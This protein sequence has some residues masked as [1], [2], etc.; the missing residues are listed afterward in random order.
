MLNESEVGK[1]VLTDFLFGNQ[2][3]IY[4]WDMKFY[5]SYSN[6]DWSST[7]VG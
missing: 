6:S 4:I 7:D 1:S 5:N 2:K 3:N